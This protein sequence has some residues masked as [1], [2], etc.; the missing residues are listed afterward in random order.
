MKEIGREFTAI[1]QD[2]FFKTLPQIYNE[3][4]TV[5]F[6]EQ[7]EKIE[8]ERLFL[9]LLYFIRFCRKVELLTN[10]VLTVGKTTMILF[11]V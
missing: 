8:K 5:R 4:I 11:P 10:L 3:G 1:S 9:L 2:F 7:P 6:K